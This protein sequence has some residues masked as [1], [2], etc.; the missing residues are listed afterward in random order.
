MEIR[1]INGEE[2]LPVRQSAMWPDKPLEFVKI[3]GDE[4][5]LHWGLFHE[6]QLV[7]VVSVFIENGE[8][9]FR[10]FATLK[11]FQGRGL[12]SSLLKF[13][14][15]DLREKNISKVWCNA[16]THKVLFY[17]R[18]GMQSVSQAFVKN[19]MSYIRM[20]LNII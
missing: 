13:M 14:L 15:E 16:R 20:E 19:G 9:Q 17:E 7:S 8:A 1:V 5:A 4:Q 18:L 12:G 2:A 6:G 10:K 11:S 3:P